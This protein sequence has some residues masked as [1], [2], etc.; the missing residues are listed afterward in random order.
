VTHDS[1]PPIETPHSLPIQFDQGPDRLSKLLDDAVQLCPLPATTHRVLQL[2]ESDKA[3]VATIVQAISNDPAL[4]T[5]VLRVANSAMYSGPRVAQLD[6]AVMRLG[7]RE[8][9][10]LATAM[11]LLASFRSRD[12][13]QVSLHDRSVLAGSI[14][15]SVAKATGLVPPSTASTCGLLCEIGAMVCLA[16]DGKQ[17]ANLWKETAH[18]PLERLARENERYTV[19]S[20]EIG[21]RFLLRSSVPEDL[22]AAVGV[23]PG[24]A[25]DVLNPLQKLCLFARSAAPIVLTGARVGTFSKLGDQLDILA[26]QAGLAQVNGHE[27]V[28]L[29]K[30]SG[31]LRSLAHC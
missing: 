24:I 9:R 15:K 19:S 1:K 14:A 5:G 30:Q 6:V 4:A 26:A 8:L 7:L 29:F 23:Q 28:D 31:L 27:L 2:A 22:C 20:F 12:G 17:Y 11:A 25:P 3:S 13:V 16:V 18:T 10:E 21:R